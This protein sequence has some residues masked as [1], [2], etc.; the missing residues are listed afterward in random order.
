MEPFKKIPPPEK[1]KIS[2]C[3]H[4]LDLAFRKAQEEVGLLAYR[5]GRWENQRGTIK[6]FSASQDF[7][8][9]HDEEIEFIF[10]VA[11][12]SK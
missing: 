3:A 12:E 10:E 2:V 8:P 6:L 11:A 9:H 5:D 7:G 4:S 1:T